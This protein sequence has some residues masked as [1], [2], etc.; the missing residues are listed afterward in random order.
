MYDYGN[1]LLADEIRE[2]ENDRDDCEQEEYERARL[3]QEG[4]TNL[5]D[6]DLELIAENEARFMIQRPQ[7]VSALDLAGMYCGRKI[8]SEV[9]NHIGEDVKIKS[10]RLSSIKGIVKKGTRYHAWIEVRISGRIG[11]SGIC[12]VLWAEAEFGFEGEGSYKILSIQPCMPTIEG[13]Q[14]DSYLVPVYGSTEFDYVARSI[15]EKYYPEALLVP[16][17]ID[18][19]VL[20]ARMALSVRNDMMLDRELTTN[21][22][23]FYANGRVPCWDGN[24]WVDT[25]VENGTVLLDSR[26]S[27]EGYH[28]SLIHECVHWYELQ[29]FFQ[30]QRWF[31]PKVSYYTCP[32][33]GA[34]EALKWPEYHAHHLPAHIQME[35]EQTLR[36]LDKLIRKWGGLSP[37]VIINM[38]AY[39]SV[40]IQA[41]KYRVIELGYAEA[42]GM[43]NYAN[44][45]Y[46]RTYYSPNF[47]LTYVI[48]LKDAFML[49]Q[50]DRHFAELLMNGQY[51]YIDGYY[52][53]DDPRYVQNGQMTDYALLHPAECCLAFETK[54]RTIWRWSGSGLLNDISMDQRQKAYQLPYEDNKAVISIAEKLKRE[55]DQ[56]KAIR[57]VMAEIAEKDFIG[58]LRYH[59][60]SKNIQPARLIEDCE[61]HLGS[62]TVQRMLSPRGI[63]PKL[64]TVIALCVILKLNAPFGMDLVEKAGYHLRKTPEEEILCCILENHYA[65][66]INQINEAL[67]GMNFERLCA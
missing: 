63:V 16:T 32:A 15:L 5:T 49:I 47:Q 59:M 43:L 7:Y 67:A 50:N 12:R 2:L 39:F 44:K 56:K 46:A 62:S 28:K 54:N 66:S 21:A 29:G 13:Q 25:Y 33:A 64:R 61:N 9:K 10:Y 6:G 31:N 52:C 40:S 8:L 17:K 18:G 26:I 57:L 34:Q 48:G 30:M 45:G 65:T 3:E 60:E 55:A 19:N 1:A 51:V 22:R 36:V 24:Q 42:K 38:A 4:I 41:A 58:T 53:I 14:Y 23:I 35:S 37:K 27:K 20:A 11:A